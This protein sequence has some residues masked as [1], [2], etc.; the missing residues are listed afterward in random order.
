MKH[1]S[2]RSTFYIV[3]SLTGLEKPELE[4]DSTSQSTASGMVCSGIGL[5]MAKHTRG[6]CVVRASE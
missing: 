2:K 1:A 6:A 3:G 4:I 5:Y